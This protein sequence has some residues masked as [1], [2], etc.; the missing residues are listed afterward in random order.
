VLRAPALLLLSVLAVVV[1]G[2]GAG[3]S[4]SAKDFDGAKRP[5]AVAVEDLQQAGEDD[6][7]AKICDDLL[8]A[9]LLQRLRQAGT[10][11]RTAVSDAL[12]DADNF[13]LDVD[14]VRIAGR[15]ATA[16][17]TSGSGDQEKTDT[18]RLEREGRAWKI[19]SLGATP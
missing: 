12:D 15:T 1:S 6:E 5:V 3:D 14:D 9:S 4:D 10:N 17:V 2:C 19:A 13:K 18:L 7:P 8:A 16:R 11:C